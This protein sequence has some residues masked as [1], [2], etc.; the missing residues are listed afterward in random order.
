M[1]STLQGGTSGFGHR[2]NMPLFQP[3]S[4]HYLTSGTVFNVAVLAYPCLW[5][6]A[7]SLHC[8]NYAK[9]K[10]A[11]L[12]LLVATWTVNMRVTSMRMKLEQRETS[13]IGMLYLFGKE[14]S[15]A[16]PSSCLLGRSKTRPCKHSNVP[17][18]GATLRLNTLCSAST[19]RTNSI[20]R[21]TGKSNE[22]SI[23]LRAQS[24]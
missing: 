22:C 12:P 21:V 6:V 10:Q 9:A 1:T 24:A 2:I 15:A 19:C 20:K 5:S 8:T 3:W 18:G 23:E 16:M 13:H 17:D 11:F 4:L 7:R 14:G